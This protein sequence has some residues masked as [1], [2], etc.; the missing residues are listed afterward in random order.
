M[1]HVPGNEQCFEHLNDIEEDQADE[2]Q[3]EQRRE[4]QR[5]F[6]IRIGDQQQITQPLVGTDELADHRAGHRQRRGDLQAAEQVR[7]AGGQAKLREHLQPARAHR[8]RQIVHLRGHRAQADR[9]VDH[10]RKERDQKRHQH[11]RQRAHAEPH[12]E[13]RRDRHLGHH[14][15]EQQRGH[16]E[17][18]E[19]L[20]RG[21]RNRQRHRN[22]DRESVADEHLVGRH[23]GVA[24]QLRELV[25]HRRDNRRGRR[26]QISRRL[27]HDHADLPQ[28][29]KHQYACE[30]GESGEQRG[31]D[32]ALGLGLGGDCFARHGVI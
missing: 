17:L 2:R 28:H 29:Q 21:D 4:H 24:Q 26:E 19:A 23:P 14:L 10:D 1:A 27:R 7:Q 18:V 30:R 32:A 5:R 15:K 8:A 20:R 12:Q 13:Q 31:A 3:R 22:G 6:E 9:R 11:L 16:D 25:D